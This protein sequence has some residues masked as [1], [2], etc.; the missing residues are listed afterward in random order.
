MRRRNPGAGGVG[1]WFSPGQ[2]C[3]TF[4]DGWLLLIESLHKDQQLIGFARVKYG[5]S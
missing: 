3:A 2:P 4:R 1:P 5:L